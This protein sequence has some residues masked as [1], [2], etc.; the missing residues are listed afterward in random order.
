MHRKTLACLVIVALLSSILFSDWAQAE[1]TGTYSSSPAGA[2][3]IVGMVLLTL[4]LVHTSEEKSEKHEEKKRDVASLQDLI[5]PLGSTCYDW[6]GRVIPCDFKGEYGELLLGSD[7]PNPRFE[8]NKNGTVTD[9]LTGLVWLKNADCFKMIDWDG[10]SEAVRNLKHG[11]CGPNPHLVLADG[12]SAGDWRLPAMEELCT[13]IDF[14]ER[15][16]A[17][18]YDNKFSGVSS[19]YYWSSTPIE[20]SSDLLWVVYLDVGT[21]CYNAKGDQAGNV[22]P[23]RKTAHL[24]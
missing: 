14:G 13:L 4:V 6:S 21:T 5:N 10:A 3:F 1:S 20:S 23:V 8:D 11:D 15:N 19:S 9:N 7:S 22:L 18:P 16:P 24:D 12:S 17:L 2:A